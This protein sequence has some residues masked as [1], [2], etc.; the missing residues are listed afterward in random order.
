MKRALLVL[1]GLLAVGAAT[2]Q[3]KISLRFSTWAGGD[4]LALLQQLAKEYSDSN[5]RVNVTVEV[6]PFADYPRKVAIQVA[7]GDAPDV[8]WLAERDVPAFLA[9]NALVDLRASLYAD[10]NFD[11]AD[12][13]T[14]ALNLWRKGGG[15]YGV[16]FSN[17]P[18]VLFYNKDLFAKAGVADPMT[19]YSRGTWDYAA[20][21]KAAEA[22]KEKTEAFGARVMR[23]DPKAWSSGTLAVL[24][25]YGG[26]VYDDKF[27]CILDSDGSVRAFTLMHDMMF[28]SGS[29]PRPGDQT[30]FETG[31]MAMYMDNVSYSAQLRTVDFKWGIAPMPKGP[32]GRITQLG[33]AGYVVFAKSKYPKE[34]IEFLAFLASKDVMARTARFFPPPRKSVLANPAYLS[35]NPLI[36]AESL[37]VALV[38]QVSSARVFL[39]PTNWLRANDVITSGL[40][41]LYQPGANLKAV[42]ND[43]CR[44]VDALQ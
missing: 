31:R 2:A 35:S 24:W 6:T 41:R 1:A 20:F 21:Q 36:P 27:K 29:M 9:S 7:S 28:K 15:I 30:T 43:I 34:A 3:Q 26:G 18:Q 42:L 33:Q 16:P 38:N 40:D 37:K 19:Q 4:G 11:A 12:F 10:R 14:S 13:P 17:S 5:P 23:L 25:S 44:Q 8:G 22:I 32:N 39:A